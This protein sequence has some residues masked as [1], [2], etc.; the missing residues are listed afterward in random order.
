[1]RPYERMI[2]YCKIHTTSD[3][4]GAATPSSPREFALADLLA[5]ELRALGVSD[6][7]RTETC[8]VYGKIPA[9]P[10]YENCPKIGWVAHLDTAPDFSGENVRP[11]IWEHYNGEDIVLPECGRVIRV[12]DFPHL[13]EKKGKTLITASGDTLLGADDKAGIAE[14]V[15][16]CERLLKEDIPH[17]PVRI[18]FTPDEEIGMGTATFDYGT[19]DADYA[20]T[21]DGGTVG[22]VVWECFNA[23]SAAVTVAGNNVH[24]GSAKGIMVNACLVAMEFNRMLPADEIPSETEGY[25]GFYHLTGL[26][27]SVEK[28]ELYYILRDHDAAKLAEREERV[29]AAAAEINRRYGEGTVQVRIR[30]GYRNMADAIRLRFE[31]VEKALT[32]TRKAGLDP[33][34]DP[35]RGGT[36]GATMTAAGLPCPNLGTGS[37][38]FHGPYEHSVAEEM[39][40]AVDIMIGILTE[41]VK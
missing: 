8:N 15:C 5:E 10:G 17:G 40:L 28:A 24:P 34:Q 41:F 13:K 18:A 36:D 27:G 29:R 12:R 16:L 22:E 32:A 3:E 19:M 39:D 9:T 33:I 7:V 2:S 31:V 26:K 25:E 11:L 38:A 23:A 37:Y 35:I 6:V 4:A 30:E 20:Y 1:M 14:I 21:M